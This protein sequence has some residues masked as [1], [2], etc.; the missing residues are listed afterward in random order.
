MSTFTVTTASDVLNADD[1]K[2]SLREAV[3]Q[4]NATTAVDTIGFASC[5]LEGET[6]VLVQGQL[7]L[8]Q[9]VTIDGD[10]NNDG[11]EVTLSGVGESRILHITALAAGVSSL[12]HKPK[13]SI[14]RAL[15]P[16]LVRN[17]GHRGHASKQYAK[18][19][20]CGWNY[21]Q[22]TCCTYDHL[23]NLKRKCT[24]IRRTTFI[25]IIAFTHPAMMTRYG[26]GAVR[27]QA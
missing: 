13:G 1:G 3:R 19:L 4:A 18:A 22:H 21:F 14:E 20:A 24:T 16:R 17:P 9:D 6:L 7:T 8:K 2:V 12:A 25:L 23:G 26:C 5:A 10:Q 15:Q 11:K 27:A